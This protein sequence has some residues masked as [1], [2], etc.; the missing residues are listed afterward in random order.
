MTL[1]DLPRMLVSEADGWRDV[2]RLHPGV[3]KML[4]A[5]VM[6]LSLLP[7]LMYAYANMA[8]PGQVFPLLEPPL[9][10]TEAWVVG[11]VFFVVEVAMVF[12][13]ADLIRQIT[14][15]MAA[16]P[17]FAQSFSLAAI[18]PV[19][20]WLASLALLVPSLWF[21]LA[22]GALAWVGTV[23]L[24]RHGVAPLLHV[25]DHDQAHRVANRIT[26]VGMA[27]WIGLVMMMALIVSAILGWR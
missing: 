4:L 20:L 16:R 25:A 27:A 8:H 19:P 10:L 15:S 23:A 13:M 7:P 26:L 5:V 18:A 21:N 3:S 6:P 2:E 1:T 12:M 14:Q 9:G 17:G 11:S 22:V 24:I